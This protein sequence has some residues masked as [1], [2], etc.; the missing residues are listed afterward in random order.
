MFSF[1]KKLFSKE[2]QVKPHSTTLT[3]ATEG[4]ESQ[5]ELSPEVE[6]TLY[7]LRT[8][9]VISNEGLNK[10]ASF[11]FNTPEIPVSFFVQKK[12]MFDG[13][14]LQIV[15]IT[16]VDKPSG[17]LEDLKVT[18]TDAVYGSDLTLTISVQLFHEFFQ[19]FQPNFD[20]KKES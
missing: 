2:T 11:Y 1:F 17:D 14:C 20:L 12:E 9:G 4:V 10:V 19:S 18:L 7:R 8:D 13:M 3:C 6:Q 5:K 16:S 15:T